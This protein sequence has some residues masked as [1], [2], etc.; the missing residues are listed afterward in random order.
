MRKNN[1]KGFV[2]TKFRLSA[3]E[4]YE[5][6]FV[7]MK[8]RLSANEKRRKLIRYYEVSFICK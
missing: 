8:F 7:I 6:G 4:K 2:I 3:N 5:K 1:E